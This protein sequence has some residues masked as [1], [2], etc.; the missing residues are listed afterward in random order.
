M[1]GIVWVEWARLVCLTASF[2]IF[3]GGILGT[4]EPLPAFDAM[5]VLGMV[6]AAMEYPFVA[7]DYFNSS[8]SLM[9]RVIFYI[10]LTVLALL[11]AQTVNGGVYLAIGTIAY[12]M[13]IRVNFKKQQSTAPGQMV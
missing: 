9:P 5:S 2:V 10:P 8:K 11:E 6:L 7:V 12:L 4:F 1:G 13:A 3:L